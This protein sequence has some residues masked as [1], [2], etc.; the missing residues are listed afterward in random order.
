MV[1]TDAG[2][3]DAGDAAQVAL[4]QAEFQ[5][6]DAVDFHIRAGH[7]AELERHFGDQP[8]PHRRHLGQV[9]GFSQEEIN[10]FAGVGELVLD[11]VVL[12]D[13]F[14]RF[15]ET[16]EHL[17]HD[18][19]RLELIGGGQLDAGGRVFTLEIGDFTAHFQG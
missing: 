6:V 5:Q 4:Q 2:Q 14:R 8:R 9:D 19:D 10:G 15:P 18:V 7:V 17:S 1:G 12:G 3:I 11:P 16:V 13:R